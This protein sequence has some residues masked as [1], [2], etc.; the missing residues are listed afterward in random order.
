MTPWIAFAVVFAT[1][2]AVDLWRSTSEVP[3][4]FAST[5]KTLFNA[6]VAL[7]F[8]GYVYWSMGQQPALEFVTGYVLEMSLSFDNVFVISMIMSGM[9]VPQAQRAR[10]LLLGIIG[11]VFLRGLFIGL[12]SALVSEFRFVLLLFAFFLIWT[13]IKMLFGDGEEEEPN[14]ENSKT[15]RFLRRWLPISKDYWDGK[16]FVRIKKYELGT[17]SKI[18]LMATPLFAAL[19]MVEVAD[20]LFAVDSI[21]AIFAITTNPFV[22]FTSNMFAVASL[23]SLFFVLEAM[24]H[25]FSKLKAA[26]SLVLVF[27]GFK[28]IYTEAYGAHINLAVALGGVLA[29]LGGGIVWSLLATRGNHGRQN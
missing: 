2:I 11:A 1:L 9:A 29:I 24:V 3:T 15:L 20:L 18:R 6:G 23:R 5:L 14:V 22:V 19:V 25:R 17:E 7:C 21:P 28:V 27:I 13:G 12:G 16:F 26:L 8:A 4:I 10:M